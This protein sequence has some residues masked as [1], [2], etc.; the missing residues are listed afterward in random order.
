MSSI[1][2]ISGEMQAVD[3]ELSGYAA[4]LQRENGEI[5]SIMNKAQS[6]FGDQQAGRACVATLYR[7]LQN[8]AAA[9]SFLHLVRQEIR[10]FVQNIRK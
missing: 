2:Q 10:G 7:T 5:T 9:D 3:A 6:A 8:V 4:R 1:E